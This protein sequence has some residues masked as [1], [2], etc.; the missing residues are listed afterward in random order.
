MCRTLPIQAI[1]RKTSEVSEGFSDQFLGEVTDS[2]NCSNLWNV[3]ATV[4]LNGKAVEFKLYTG[5][6]VGLIPTQL[7]KLTPYSQQKINKQVLV[8]NH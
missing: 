4:M 5:A 8:V 7:F 3:Y 2:T 1:Q 6:D